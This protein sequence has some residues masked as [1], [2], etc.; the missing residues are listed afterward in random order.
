MTESATGLI[1]RTR[2][3]TETSLIV[4][5]LTPNFGRIAT[6]AKGARRAKSPF[7]GKLDLFYLADFSFNRSRHSDLHQLREVSLRE[8]HVAIRADILKLQQAAYATNF[9]EQA[10][11]TETPLPT[12]YELLREFLGSLCRVKTTPQLVFSFELKLLRE[13]GL[14]PNLA[15]TNLA[16]GTKKIAEILAQKDWAAGLRLKL[17]AAQTIE[18]RQFL[19]GFLIFYLSRLPKGRTV[20]MAG[21][22]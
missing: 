18:L 6:V 2:P 22:I 17:T 1:L 8:T 11:E 15:E 5:W 12:V 13:L 14:E 19:H 4:H 10:T 20:A 9:I 21:E 3:L 7:L 16:A